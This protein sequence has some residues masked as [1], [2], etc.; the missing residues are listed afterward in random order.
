MWYF[1]A[2]EHYGHANIIEHCDRPFDSVEAMDEALIK[3]PDLTEV[4]QAGLIPGS[5]LATANRI[6][7][8]DR[9]QVFFSSG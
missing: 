2:D 5:R 4:P 3:N 7:Q 1:T 6:Q 9:N 8:T